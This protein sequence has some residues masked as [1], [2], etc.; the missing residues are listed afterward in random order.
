M[1]QYIHTSSGANAM[2]CNMYIIS[3]ANNT[4]IYIS[5]DANATFFSSE[6]NIID[7][8]IYIL[9]QALTPYIAS[10]IFAQEL[11]LFISSGANVIGHNIYCIHISSGTN[12][13]H[14]N[15]C[16]VL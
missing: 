9:T 10:C 6:A 13:I 14:C 7:C 5:S 16:S 12:A 11:M 3:G 15:M 1:S 8:N 2:Y 4:C